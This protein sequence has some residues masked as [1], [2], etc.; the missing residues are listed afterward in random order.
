MII[1]IEDMRYFIFKTL[2]FLKKL[3]LFYAQI[4]GK[5]LLQKMFYLIYLQ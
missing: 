2:C 1:Y 3:S 5:N 4:Q